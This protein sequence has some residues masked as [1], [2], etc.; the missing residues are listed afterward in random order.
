MT[1]ANRFEIFIIAAM[2]VSAAGAQAP[3]LSGVSI[4]TTSLGNGMYMLEATGDVAGN[5]AVS[6]GE[7]GILIVDDQFEGLTGQILDSLQAVLQRAAA[8]HSQ[9]GPPRRPQ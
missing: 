1:I 2:Y 3:D 6:V 5:I 4:V 7:D 9:H 8:L